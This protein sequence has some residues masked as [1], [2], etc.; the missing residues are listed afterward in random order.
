[1]KINLT[2]IYYAR[3][4]STCM[5]KDG[6][7]LSFY[8]SFSEAQESANYIGFMVPYLCNNCGNYHLKPEAF[9]C[10]KIKRSCN[11]V[12]HNGKP[13]DTYKT[14]SDALKMVNIRANAGITLNIYKCPQGYGYHLT[15]RSI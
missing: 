5:N 7:P 14:K 2:N 6:K 13:K 1:M 10:E 15:S 8:S 3:K 11:C 4:S 9:Y 12:D